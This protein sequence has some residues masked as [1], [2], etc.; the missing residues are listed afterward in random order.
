MRSP[1]LN[2]S[3]SAACSINE[4]GAHWSLVRIACGQALESVAANQFITRLAGEGSL[5]IG[6]DRTGRQERLFHV[7]PAISHGM[8]VRTFFRNSRG[9]SQGWIQ[10]GKGGMRIPAGV[11]RDDGDRLLLAVAIQINKAGVRFRK[12]LTLGAGEGESAEADKAEKRKDWKT[13]G[14]TV[15]MQASRLPRKRKILI[16]AIFL[17]FGLMA[18][19]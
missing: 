6:I 18:A 9:P 19:K 16:G 10:M 3:G 2:V 14:K 13:H 11:A 1:D 4:H 7:T 5:R 15:F 17:V 12:T 8:C